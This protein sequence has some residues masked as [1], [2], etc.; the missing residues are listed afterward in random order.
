MYMCNMAFNEVKN[1]PK[2]VKT[3]AKMIPLIHICVM[4]INEDQIQNNRKR[5]FIAVLRFLQNTCNAII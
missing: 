3:E 5:V 2:I 4:C 1:P